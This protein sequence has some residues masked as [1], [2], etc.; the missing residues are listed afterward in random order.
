MLFVVG[1]GITIAL[2]VLACE[3]FMVPVTRMELTKEGGIPFPVTWI[4]LRN[5]TIDVLWPWKLPWVPVYTSCAFPKVRYQQATDADPFG[6]ICLETLSDPRHH[7]V[8]NLQTLAKYVFGDT[9]DPMCFVVN[10]D[11]S[12]PDVEPKTATWSGLRPM[13]LINPFEQ[14][15]PQFPAAIIFGFMDLKTTSELSMK[16]GGYAFLDNATQEGRLLWHW[17]SVNQ[18]NLVNLEYEVMTNTYQNTFFRFPWYEG[19]TRRHYKSTVNSIPGV[20]FSTFSSQIWFGFDIRFSTTMV[21]K[22]WNENE[23]IS[24]LVAAISGAIKLWAVILAIC[25]VERTLHL[26]PDDAQIM[27]KV[28]MF[29]GT[30]R[31]VQQRAADDYAQ[32]MTSRKVSLSSRRATTF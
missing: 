11:S 6:E 18:H 5:E 3:K 10:H 19:T 4:C 27:T 28:T 14:K 24:V 9:A 26:G 8:A 17:G 23:S 13:W 29:R 22:V 1:L 2:L 21:T 16:S 20:H 15:L 7:L 30:R 25:F 12:V 32:E 31:D